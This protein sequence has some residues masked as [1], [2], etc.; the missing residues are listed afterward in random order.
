MTDVDR[1]HKSVHDE[2]VIGIC[3]LLPHETPYGRS[4]AR[5]CAGI[6]PEFS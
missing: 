4:V 5:Q 3:I 2:F 1:L 6:L